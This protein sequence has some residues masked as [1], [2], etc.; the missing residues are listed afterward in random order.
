MGLH[1]PLSKAMTV[2]KR[3]PIDWAVLFVGIVSLATVRPACAQESG[4]E[5]QKEPGFLKTLMRD[6]LS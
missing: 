4:G 6:Q 1:I 3:F 2:S 5:T